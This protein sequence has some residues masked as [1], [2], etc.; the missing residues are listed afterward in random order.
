MVEW[1]G[2]DPAADTVVSLR[3]M[4]RWHTGAAI[5]D[6]QAHQCFITKHQETAKKKASETPQNTV[7]QK[8]Q[9]ED[10]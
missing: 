1:V 6:L 2:K 3:A 7:Q 4:D 9:R 8:H 10:P 5:L